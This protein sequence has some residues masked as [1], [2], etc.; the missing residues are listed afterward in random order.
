VLIVDAQIHLWTRGVPGPAHRGQPYHIDQA[1]ADMDAA[2]VDASLIV[3]PPWDPGSNALALRAARLH[4]HRFAVMGHLAAHDPAVAPSFDVLRRERGMLG[5]R[6]AFSQPATRSGLLEGTADWLWP[7]AAEAQVPIAI[8]APGLLGHVRDIA[9]RHPRLKLIVDHMGLVTGMRDAQ[10]FEPVL[11][12]LAA[13][14]QLPNVSIKLSS[15]PA[16]SSAPFPYKNV[17]TYLHTL[18]EMFGARRCFWGSDITRLPCT[19]HQA[20]THFTEHLRWLSDDDKALI[21]GRA[22]CEWLSWR[23]P[24]P[25]IPHADGLGQPGTA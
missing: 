20:V 8:F 2:G 16:Y 5:L 19:W 21:M 18:V 4:P 13:L 24:L 7:L 6:V 23:D 11:A 9:H 17:D 14:A 12:P 25:R 3:P 15:A 22:L 10:A 1:V